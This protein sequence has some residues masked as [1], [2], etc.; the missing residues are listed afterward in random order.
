[1]SLGTTLWIMWITLQLYPLRWKTLTRTGEV[2]I[3]VRD[4]I[5]RTKHWPTRGPRRGLVAPNRA[6][7][8]ADRGA[9]RGVAVAG[10]DRVLISVT[11]NRWAGLHRGSPMSV[12][13]SHIWQA[14]WSSVTGVNWWGKRSPSTP[15]R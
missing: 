5:W 9:R 7:V 2:A 13:G 3:S 8:N 12:A 6:F 1:P 14:G 11:R 15:S 4:R 10:Q